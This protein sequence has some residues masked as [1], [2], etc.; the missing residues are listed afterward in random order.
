M[1]HDR[2]Y[3]PGV[4][5]A[6]LLSRFRLEIGKKV[7]FMSKAIPTPHNTWKQ[8]MST[9]PMSS[10]PGTTARDSE[11]LPHV[12]NSLMEFLDSLHSSVDGARKNARA[13]NRTKISYQK[14]SRASHCTTCADDLSLGIVAHRARR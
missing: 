5:L 1:L 13:W 3:F 4:Y 9:E 10:K 11:A 7:S 8:F 6:E 2:E 14:G 12:D